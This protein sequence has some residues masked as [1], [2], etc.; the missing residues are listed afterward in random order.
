M[1]WG[2]FGLFPLVF[3][4]RNVGRE[5]PCTHLVDEAGKLGVEGLYL[6]LLLAAY[7]V[8]QWVDPN[9]EGLQE[10]L[11]DADSLDAVSLA[12][13]VASD[14]AV[15]PGATKADPSSDTTVAY[16]SEAEVSETSSTTDPVHVGNSP[17]STQVADAPAAVG[18]S[19]AAGR[20]AGGGGEA[21]AADLRG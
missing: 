20:L 12:I 4:L 18:A 17:A 19:P 10:P 21:S 8:L 5:Q 1:F 15:S 9:A 16:T 6:L 14:D 11:V 13:R 7:F 2:G 3:P